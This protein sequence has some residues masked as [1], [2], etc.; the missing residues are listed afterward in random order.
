MV[1]AAGDFFFFF[2]NFVVVIFTIFQGALLL[3]ADKAQEQAPGR[4]NIKIEKPKVQYTVL[5]F[6]PIY[7]YPN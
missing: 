7:F 2:S 1:Y 5:D 3:T 4:V 6:H